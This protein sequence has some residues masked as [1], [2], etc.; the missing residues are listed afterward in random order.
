LAVGLVAPRPHERPERQE[1]RA[2]GAADG[3]DLF[4]RQAHVLIIGRTG[5]TC[6]QGQVA[7]LSDKSY[8]EDMSNKPTPPAPKGKPV[9]FPPFKS[10][11]GKKLREQLERRS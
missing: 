11:A 2:D 7:P 8:N 3:D 5:G 1:Q 4:G 9:E 10:E 6:T